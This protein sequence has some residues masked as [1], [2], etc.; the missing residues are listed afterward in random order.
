MYSHH[1]IVLIGIHQLYTHT[2]THK[3]QFGRVTLLTHLHT[4]LQHP[5]PFATSNFL[6][7]HCARLLEILVHVLVVATS[8][9]KVQFHLMI[10]VLNIK[11]G[12]SILPLALKYPKVVLGMFITTL[13]PNV[14][15]SGAAGSIHFNNYK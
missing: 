15:G 7:L 9:S 8:I 3:G 11:S 6:H 13:T 2:H 1:T 4:F 12:V 14:L 5:Q 10:S